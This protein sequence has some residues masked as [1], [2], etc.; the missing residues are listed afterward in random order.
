M[1]GK[2]CFFI[3]PIGNPETETRRA[4]EGLIESVL[5]PICKELDLELCVAH[6]VNNPGSIT[7][8]VIQRLLHSDM[9]IAN[10]S[11]LNPNVMY[12][13]AVRHATRLPVVC[14]AENGTKL[15]FDLSDERTLFFENDM[16]GV[17]DLRKALRPTVE[18]ALSTS[19]SIDN[20]ITRA[21]QLFRMMNAEDTPDVSKF[22]MGKLA[23]LE[24]LIRDFESSTRVIT[25]EKDYGYEVK[26]TGK[27]DEV[28]KFFDEVI[29]LSWVETIKLSKNDDEELCVLDILSISK[30][31][32]HGVIENIMQ[33]YPEL[34]C[35]SIRRL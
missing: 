13:L 15:P 35:R 11:T 14:I 6:K 23:D 24:T 19:N 17:V 9:V 21:E 12:E 28:L 3:T 26:V 8:D 27:R 5:S 25:V 4:T 1:A 22:I 7:V 29:G 10:L 2:S 32:P 16:H 33:K 30:R 31:T 20:P 34:E 18:A